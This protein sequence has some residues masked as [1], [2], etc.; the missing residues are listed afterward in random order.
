M[1]ESNGKAIIEQYQE[2]LSE[3]IKSIWDLTSRLDERVQNIIRKQDELERK[4]ENTTDGASELAQRVSAVEV[5][6]TATEL[7]K[8]VA[9]MKKTVHDMEIDVRDLKKEYGKSHDRWKQVLQFGL[10]VL[11]A[12]VIAYLVFKLHLKS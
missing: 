4:H 10:Q 11:S 3:S 7:A 8:E 5:K 1:S 6:A 2:Q 9:E 12:I